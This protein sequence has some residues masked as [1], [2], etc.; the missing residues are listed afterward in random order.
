[1]AVWRDD[2]AAIRPMLAT[3]AEPPLT[4]KGLV[5]EPKYDGI[6][7]IVHVPP[8]GARD[9]VRIWS[10]LGND[11]TSQFPSIVRSLDPVRARL[12]APVLI[13][14]EIVAL[15]AQGRPAGFQRLQG[16]IHLSGAGDVERIDHTQPVALI[17]FDVLRD[18]DDDLRGRP[19]DQ[20]RTHL[21][22]LLKD[23]LSPGLRLS[24]Q[25]FDD[26]RALHERAQHEGWEGLIV[27]EVKSPY[28]TGRRSPAWRK[29]KL[30]QQQEF[31]VGGWT[32]PRQ[33]RQH[34]GALLLGVRDSSGALRYVGHTGTGF[35]QKELT[36]VS[37][38]L[39][40][41]QVP[42]S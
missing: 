16:R 2:P 8:K 9:A 42:H 33:S 39:R 36:R 6:R 7:A 20:R 26:G 37:S 4:G 3:L 22:R 1:M 25:A 29:L 15:D 5:F 17:A 23:A 13:D 21:D 24:E 41:R 18:G 11:K 30:V 35:D 34:F 32:E 10:R 12:N 27:K 19:L 31:I 38:L 40:A 28:Q 14:G